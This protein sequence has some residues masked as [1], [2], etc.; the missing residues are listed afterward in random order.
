MEYDRRLLAG[1]FAGA[2]GGLAGGAVKLLCEKIAP[3]RPFWRQ[4]PP[5]VLAAEVTRAVAGEDL[6]KTQRERTANVVH[7]VFS[8]ATGALYGAVA[9][10]FPRATT[11]SGTLFGTIVWAG[12]H[13]VVL[14]LARATPP[15]EELPASEQIN[16]FI[17]HALYGA[18]V[19]GV[20]GLL[21]A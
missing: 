21:R 6:T 16:E 9:E 11:G 19:E 7:W 12:F 15:L 10:K 14:P 1:A 13:E 8:I 2:A 3:P 17:T 5:G 4:P 20:R 18:T